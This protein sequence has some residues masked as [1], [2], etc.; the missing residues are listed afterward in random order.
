M[1]LYILTLLLGAFIL[2]APMFFFAQ[3]VPPGT[4]HWKENLYI[5]KYEVTNIAYRE[6]MYWQEKKFGKDSDEYGAILP[7]S[8]VWQKESQFG[9]INYLLHPIYS[10]YPVIGLSW[11][12]AM[13]YTKWRSDRVN[14]FYYLNEG[15]IERDQLEAVKT[16]P[17]VYNYRLPGLTEW[18]ELNNIAYS[19]R[20]LKKVCSG[21][22]GKLREVTEGAHNL[23]KIYNLESGVSELTI[24]PDYAMGHNWKDPESDIE[25]RF[26]KAESW[27]GFRCICEMV[28]VDKQ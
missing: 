12:Q 8:T 1:K 3:D 17:S 28:P 14:E 25:K 7:D 10:H 9:G 16:L 24:A 5:D 20:Q 15:K 11:K 23:M 19:S 13:A 18:E 21:K 2:F 4:V 26:T 6:F 22:Q 27:I